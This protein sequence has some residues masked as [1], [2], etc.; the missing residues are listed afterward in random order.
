VFANGITTQSTIVTGLTAGTS[1]KFV[2]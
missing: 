1:Y 2:V